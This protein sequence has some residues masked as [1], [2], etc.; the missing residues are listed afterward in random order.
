MKYDENGFTL[1]EMVTSVVLTSLMM[2]AVVVFAMSFWRYGYV[3]DA[4]LDSLVTRL[5]AGDYL[6]ENLGTST[7]LVTQNGLSD[8]NPSYPDPTD[9]TNEHWIPIHAVPGNKIIG[10]NGTITPLL[11]YKRLSFDSSNQVIMN[12]V[13]P[14]QDEY[15]LYMNGT[16]KQLLVRSLANPS[17]TGNRLKTSCPAALASLTCPA[18][19][20]IA[21]DVA[22]VDFRYF[23]R[24]GNTMN[25]SSIIDPI[26]GEYAGP[27]FPAVEVIELKLNLTSKILL[28]QA[29][30]STSTIIRI[31]LRNT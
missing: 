25:Y 28:Q 23:S 21:S 20:I 22:S 19:K 27:D 6:R 1:A 17:A 10:G 24:S 7:G 11:Y 9:P 5:N 29:N 12:G 13:Q 14:F 3:L 18:D 31:A 8:A 15:V 4:S 30:N 2:G 16:T 26:T